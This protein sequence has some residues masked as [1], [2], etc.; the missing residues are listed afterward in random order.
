MKSNLILIIQTGLYGSVTDCISTVQLNLFM[1]L[2]LLVKLW[3][4]TVRPKTLE[5]SQ[6]MHNY[7]CELKKCEVN[8]LNAL[9]QN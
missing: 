1:R 9:P 6:I 3:S 2:L 8:W 5:I 4:F 7:I